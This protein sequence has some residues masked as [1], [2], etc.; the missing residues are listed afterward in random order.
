MHK[1]HPAA[2]GV[3]LVILPIGE[4]AGDEPRDIAA[5]PD[6]VGNLS[7]EQNREQDEQGMGV[8]DAATFMEKRGE[9]VYC[10]HILTSDS[11]HITAPG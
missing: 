11:L 5:Q 7:A 1:N 9:D 3:V 6:Y 4:E 2:R 10:L 8:F